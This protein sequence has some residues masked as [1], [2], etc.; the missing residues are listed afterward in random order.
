[1]AV[2]E[3]QKDL[4]EV[5]KPFY[6]RASEAEDRLSRIEAALASDKDTKNVELLETIIELQSRLEGANVELALQQEKAKRLSTENAKLQYRVVHLVRAVREGD[7]KR[8]KL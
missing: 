6:Q 7:T 3:T 2:S 4:G 8:E 1:M 5:L